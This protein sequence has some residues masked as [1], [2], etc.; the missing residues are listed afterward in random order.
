MG[1]ASPAAPPP[2]CCWNE[3]N[4]TEVTSFLHKPSLGFLAQKKRRMHH[5]DRQFASQPDVRS[6]IDFTHSAGADSSLQPVSPFQNVT[7]VH[8]FPL[9]APATISVE[10]RFVPSGRRRLEARLQG[11][12]CEPSDGSDSRPTA[13]E[14]RAPEGVDWPLPTPLCATGPPPDERRQRK[15]DLTTQT[16]IFPKEYTLAAFP[17]TSGFSEA[18]RQRTAL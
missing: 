18:A 13:R 11:L 7:N 14:P 6:E 10:R 17:V 5:F 3:N 9:S 2:Q 1:V 15:H 16:T 12:R 8:T 4:T